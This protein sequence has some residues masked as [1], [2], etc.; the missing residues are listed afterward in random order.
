MSIEDA[1]YDRAIGKIGDAIHGRESEYHESCIVLAKVRCDDYTQI[2]Y[3]VQYL[4]FCVID[5]QKYEGLTY[6]GDEKPAIKK[7]L[8][9]YD[10]LHPDLAK[11]LSDEEYSVLLN[12]ICADRGWSWANLSQEKRSLLYELTES[13]RLSERGKDRTVVQ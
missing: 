7:L 4:S 6:H 11:P 5:M 12:R 2:V 3:D 13:Y 1:L 10:K 8:D 9:L